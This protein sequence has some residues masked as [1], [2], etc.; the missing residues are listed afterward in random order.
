MLRIVLVASNV[1]IGLVLG[2]LLFREALPALS[3]YPT[4][5]QWVSAA[6]LALSFLLAFFNAAYIA[7][8][9]ARPIPRW[10]R[11]KQAWRASSSRQPPY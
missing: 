1:L 10:E 5:Y 8:T 6:L 11:F 2:W 9:Q 4:S 7:N 3:R